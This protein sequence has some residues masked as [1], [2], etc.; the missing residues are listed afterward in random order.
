GGNTK[1]R[2]LRF[3]WNMKTTSSLH[4]DSIIEEIKRVLKANN[5][6]FDQSEKY[7]LVCM[8]GDA[9][10]DSLVQWEM[11]VCKLPRLSLNGVRFKRISGT[12][13]GFKNVASKIANELNL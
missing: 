12:S 9:A 2:S 6:D 8:H 1:P 11:E 4:P 3:T 10:T 7:L 5:C 13:I